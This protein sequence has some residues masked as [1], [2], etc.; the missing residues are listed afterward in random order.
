[1]NAYNRSR[2]AG[3]ASAIAT[4]KLERGCADCGYDA[5]PEALQFDHLPGNEKA[6]GVAEMI[7]KAASLEAVL[8]ETEKCEVV[9]ANCHSVR[10]SER[11]LLEV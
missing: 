10:T 1:M 6:G 8:D 4:L 7:W 3:I 9:C 11:R 5:R 2:R